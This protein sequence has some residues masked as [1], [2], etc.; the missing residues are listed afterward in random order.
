MSLLYLGPLHR[1]DILA[2]GARIPGPLAHA[3]EG[4]PAV[5][6]A[7]ESEA[8]AI[9][10]E[11]EERGYADGLA[12]GQAEMAELL[13]QVHMHAGRLAAEMQ[14][15][16]ADC[17]V[18]AVRK[19]LDDTDPAALMVRA[20]ERVRERLADEN[21]LVLIL[22]PNRLDGGMEAARQLMQ[23]YGDTLPIRV[24]GNAALGPND[25]IIES[26]LGCAEVRRDAQL[27]QLRH[28]IQ[29]AFHSV[30]MDEP[31]DESETEREEEA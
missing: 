13:A 11:A 27:Q 28:L 4:A 29:A 15:L 31:E 26:A 14:P 9:R 3:M 16:L 30:N 7:A 18:Q 6:A 8:H 2:K 5:L 20:V 25:W 12:R 24:I 17:V 23:R 22:S 10:R 21:G 1:A 19:L